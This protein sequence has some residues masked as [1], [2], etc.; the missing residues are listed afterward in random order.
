VQ[1]SFD[2]GRKKNLTGKSI[3]DKM[4]KRMK[5]NMMEI[6]SFFGRMPWEMKKRRDLKLDCIKI[7][8]FFLGGVN[9]YI[10]M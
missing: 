4:K 1:L 9:R 5:K 10:N 6:C 7:G 8:L 3:D 2:F